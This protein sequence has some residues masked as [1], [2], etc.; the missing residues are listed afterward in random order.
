MGSVEGE[1]DYKLAK[2]ERVNAANKGI[3]KLFSDLE[4]AMSRKVNLR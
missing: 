3:L 4:A 1:Y 2:K